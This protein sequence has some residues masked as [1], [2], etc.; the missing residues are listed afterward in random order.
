MWSNGATTEDISNIAAGNYTVTI[1]DTDGC[2]DSEVYTVNFDASD[3]NFSFAETLTDAG[4][5]NNDGAIDITVSGGNG[6][7][8]YSWSNGASTEDLS[9]VPAGSYTVI[10]TDQLGCTS[11]RTYVVDTIVGATDFFPS[12]T[13]SNETCSTGND[14][15]IDV[16]IGSSGNF[17]YLWSNGVTTEDLNNVSNG[18]YSL[19][20]TNDV[21]CFQNLSY[22]V[23][24]TPGIKSINTN[25]VIVNE[26]CSG[27]DGSI[28]VNPVGGTAPYSYSWSTS[29]TTASTANLSAGT[30]FL[31]VTDQNGCYD[32]KTYNVGFTGGQT[33]FNIAR[34]INNATCSGSDGAIFLSTTGG[35]WPYTYQW[36][37]GVTTQNIVNVT[38]GNYTVTVT[39]ARGC[40]ST[41]NFTI[42]QNVGQTTFNLANFFVQPSCGNTGGVI[43]QS[44]GGGNPP[45]TY[46]WSNGATTQDL[47]GLSAGTYTCTITDVNGCFMDTSYT[48]AIVPAQTSFNVVQNIADESCNGNDGSIN[49]SIGGGVGPYTFQWSDGSTSQDLNNVSAGSYTVTITDAAGCWDT[50]VYNIVFTPGLSSAINISGGVTS[51]TCVLN[52]GAITANPS[53]GTA[54]YTYVW[55]NGATTQSISNINTGNYTVTVS[56]QNGCYNIRNYFV[57]LDTTVAANYQINSTV[58]NESCLLNDGSIILNT[59]FGGTG[60]FTYLW[61]NGST[62]QNPSG[63]SAGT[64]SLTI[65][66]Q[67]G[68]S[69]NGFFIVGFNPTNANFL[70][71]DSIV[72]EACGQ[73]NGL[74]SI[75]VSGGSGLYSYLWSNGDTASV[76]SGLPAGTY[77]V[78]IADTNGCATQQSYSLINLPGPA[79]PLISQVQDTLISSQAVSYQWFFNGNIIAGATSQSH[80]YTQS[81]YYY[82]QISDD[83]GCISISDSVMVTVIGIPD[84]DPEAT[85]NVFPNP[86]NDYL[87]VVFSSVNSKNATVRV[88]NMLGQSV[89]QK[90]I[91]GDL[92]DFRMRIDMGNLNAGM[93]LFSIET[94]NGISV[95]RVIKE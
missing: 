9:N 49:L 18:T 27:A 36:S 63:L 61:S 80:V 89:Y 31:I 81:G 29:S 4:C 91:Q 54:P 17:T 65:N 20:V 12:Q 74:I 45:Y 33:S 13:T 95:K 55:S 44:L 41:D 57:P 48:L 47:T 35:V 7:Y 72:N 87:D 75:N 76:A 73:N 2:F 42:S 28:T 30:Y 71:L 68:C 86:F 88:E 82:V 94:E 3:G 58:V 69:G 19:T 38:A 51:A 39:D 64:Y 50:R 11:T 25:E 43:F 83:R 34:T 16:T 52:N 40:F 46:Q 77:N 62:V 56:D 10:A 67:N 22:T 79:T 60:N 37:T 66:D 6:A 21:G 14:G 26:S 90:Q 5:D 8:T 1:T 85:V 15:S 78:T 32:N 70:V 84:V 59:I 93:Y 24:I 53:G 23:N 92:F